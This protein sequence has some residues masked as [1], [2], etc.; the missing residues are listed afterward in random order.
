MVDAGFKVVVVEQTET[1]EEAQS[2][3]NKQSGA[4]L[5]RKICEVYTAGRFNTTVSFLMRSYVHQYDCKFHGVVYV[6]YDCKFPQAF[7]C[8]IRL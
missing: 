6:Q 1:L 7:L 5:E 3:Q 8:S 2:R 4:L